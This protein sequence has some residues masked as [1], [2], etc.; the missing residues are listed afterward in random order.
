SSKALMTVLFVTLPPIAF[1][2]RFG[3]EKALTLFQRFC[4]FAIFLNLAYIVAF[5]KYAIMGGDA[6][7]RGMFAHKNQFGPFMAIALVMQLPGLTRVTITSIISAAACLLAFAFVVLSRSASAW[8]MLAAAAPLF[9]TFRAVLSLRA[10]L[11]RH[12]TI[13]IFGIVAVVGL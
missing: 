13:A 10:R 3:V 9:V 12:I 4:L 6:G 5:R 2:A 11:T 8:M 1:A 7:F